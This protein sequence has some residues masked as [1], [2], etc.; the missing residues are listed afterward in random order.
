MLGAIFWIVGLIIFIIAAIRGAK[1]WGFL[2]G[3][4][5]FLA[6]LLLPGFAQYLGFI[7]LLAYMFIAIGTL[8]KVQQTL[9]SRTMKKLAADS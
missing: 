3:I 5:I 9:T 1:A 8:A 6:G 4:G 2:A 7:G